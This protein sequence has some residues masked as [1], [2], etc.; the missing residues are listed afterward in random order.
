MGSPILSFAFDSTLTT[1]EYILAT[2]MLGHPMRSESWWE[3]RTL[4][5]LTVFPLTL[6]FFED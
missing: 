6:F 5:A 3:Q 1:G 2:G 4:P